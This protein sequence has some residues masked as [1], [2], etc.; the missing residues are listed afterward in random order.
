MTEIIKQP[1]TE[2]GLIKQIL[3][4]FQTDHKYSGLKQKMELLIKQRVYCNDG[5]N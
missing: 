2:C 4:N 1:E 3:G 5:N